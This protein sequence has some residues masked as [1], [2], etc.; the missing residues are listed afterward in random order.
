MGN[1][2]AKRRSSRQATQ[3]SWLKAKLELGYTL[4]SLSTTIENANNTEWSNQVTTE[5]FAIAD[6]YPP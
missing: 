3:T 1:F 5:K 2:N 4:V 6:Y